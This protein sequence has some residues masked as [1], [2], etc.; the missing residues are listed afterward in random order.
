MGHRS[1][2]TTS[3]YLHV[4]AGKLASAGTPL[5]LLADAA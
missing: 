2:Q 5:D 1:I 3:I 4:S